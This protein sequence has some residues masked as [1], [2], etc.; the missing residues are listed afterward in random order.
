MNDGNKCRQYKDSSFA[1]SIYF[2]NKK[3]L[4]ETILDVLSWSI[5]C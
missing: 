4:P 2:L 1:Y 3:N 5:N